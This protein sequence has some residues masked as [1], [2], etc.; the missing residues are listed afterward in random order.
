MSITMKGGVYKR[1]RVWWIK[2]SVNGRPVRESAGTG[3]YKE[4]KRLRDA[5]VQPGQR[6]PPLLRLVK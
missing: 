4:A 5:K 3:D 6:R 2:Y 1:G